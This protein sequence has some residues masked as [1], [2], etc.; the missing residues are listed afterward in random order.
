MKDLQQPR[1]PNDLR[2]SGDLEQDASQIHEGLFCEVVDRFG[3]ATMVA[4]GSSMLPAIWPGDELQVTKADLLHLRPGVVVVVIR[5]GKTIAHRIVRTWSEDREWYCQT[6]GDSLARP[7]EPC[8]FRDII[9]VA[10]TRRRHGQTHEIR[11]QAG[12]TK[13]VGRLCAYSTP[14]AKVMIVAERIA[15]ARR[16]KVPK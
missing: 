3:E 6:Q 7:D 1:T 9:G 16:R 12:F 5:Q 4:W 11:K 14:F 8:R 13:A 10:S 15:H 2:D